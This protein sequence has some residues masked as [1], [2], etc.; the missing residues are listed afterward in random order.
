MYHVFCLH[1]FPQKGQGAVHS[2][3]LRH[4]KTPS[5][6]DDILNRTFPRQPWKLVGGAIGLIVGEILSH[7]EKM[8]IEGAVGAAPNTTEI[9][10]F[11]FDKPMSA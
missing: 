7:N 11:A 2:G 4:A 8:G 9:F 6:L 3:K 5:Q 1:I 10:V